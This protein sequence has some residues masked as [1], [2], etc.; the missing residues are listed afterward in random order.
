MALE[1]STHIG[2]E[3][4]HV[5]QPLAR[6]RIAVFREFPYLYDGHIAYEIDYLQTYVRSERAMVYA[7]WYETALIGA[8]TC[9]PMADETA[10]VQAPFRAQGMD[11]GGIFYFGESVCLPRWRGQ[12]LGHHFMDVREAHADSYGGYA[13]TCFCAVQR[14]EDHPLRPANHRP[15][16]GFWTAR[17]YVKRPDLHTTMSWQDLNEQAESPKPMVFWLRSEPNPTATP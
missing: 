10:E 2:A 9:I 14:P 17:G 15:L 8:T 5:L 12:G 3:I 13:T 1:F 11:V 16:D 6:L 7:A 4:L